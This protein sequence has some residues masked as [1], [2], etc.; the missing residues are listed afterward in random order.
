MCALGYFEILGKF[1]EFIRLLC[2]RHKKYCIRVFFLYLGKHAHKIR[3]IFERRARHA[4][5]ADNERAV[6]YSEF[7][8]RCAALLR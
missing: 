2:A 7:I 3:M 8:A 1:S 4:D 6:A 5:M